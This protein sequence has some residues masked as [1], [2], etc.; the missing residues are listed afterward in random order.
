MNQEIAPVRVRNSRAGSAASVFPELHPPAVPK[1]RREKAS[2]GV[3]NVFEVLRSNAEKHKNNVENQKDYVRTTV[4]SF[5]NMH[6]YGD[7]LV[8]YLELRKS[9]FIDRLHWHVPQADGMEFDQYDTPFCRWVIL[10]EFGEILGA[11][12]LLPTTASCGV[13]SYMLR[14]AQRGLLED[15]PTDVLYFDAPQ[16]PRI[17]EASRFFITS[18]V[19]ARVRSQVQKKLFE[20]MAAT[21]RN[22]G[23]RYI[24]GIVPSV[25]SRWARRLNVGAS[26]IGSQF[27]IEGTSSQAVLFQTSD[28]ENI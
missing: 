8:R 2:T 7:L 10:H 14:D 16:N 6:E 20:A 11:V 3:L 18:A 23:A 12:R 1:E 5:R 4:M 21:A 25:W 28:M 15:L 17:W 19:S 13:Y 22:N 9:V 26:P 24:I 27:S